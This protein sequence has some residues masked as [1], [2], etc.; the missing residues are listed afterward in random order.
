MRVFVNDKAVDVPQGARV[1][2]AVAQAD[3]GLA[4]LL[5][6]GGGGAA[7]VTD[8]PPRPGAPRGGGGRRLCDGR[9][10]PRDRRR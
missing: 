8:A 10:R 5:D 4:R 1:R 9:R 7:N 6:A 2:D 3:D